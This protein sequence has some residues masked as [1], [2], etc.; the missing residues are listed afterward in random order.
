[1]T[2]KARRDMKQRMEEDSEASR[3]EVSIVGES[4]KKNDE[5][6][7]KMGQQLSTL[8]AGKRCEDKRKLRQA[9]SWE[10]KI[11]KMRHEDSREKKP[12]K[13]EAHKFHE[14]EEEKK[15]RRTQKRL[16]KR[17]RSKEKC[18]FSEEQEE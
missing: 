15:K 18:E 13:D 12:R 3:D 1:M 17:S 9:N 7:E 10:L 8:L 11:S 6:Q 14:K 16:R 5:A 2:W 4:S